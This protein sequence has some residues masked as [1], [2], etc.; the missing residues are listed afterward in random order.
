M[1]NAD[2]ITSATVVSDETIK[3]VVAPPFAGLTCRTKLLDSRCS[4]PNS[5]LLVLFWHIYCLS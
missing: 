3:C 5:M 1:S 4:H 2:Y